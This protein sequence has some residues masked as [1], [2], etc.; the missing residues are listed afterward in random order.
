MLE[1]WRLEVGGWRLEVFSLLASGIQFLVSQS[2]SFQ[3]SRV[4]SLTTE[5]LENVYAPAWCR[6]SASA[7]FAHAQRGC[8]IEHPH[9]G[10]DQNNS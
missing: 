4:G 10:G 6:S 7:N 3:L 2:P 1:P 8:E 5:M 9:A